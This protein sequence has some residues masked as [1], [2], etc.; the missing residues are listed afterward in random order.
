LFSLTTSLFSL[1]CFA[2]KKLYIKANTAKILLTN[3]NLT[4]P[5]AH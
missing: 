4:P 5:P 3:L 2:I 1:A